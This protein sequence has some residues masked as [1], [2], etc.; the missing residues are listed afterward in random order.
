MS[1][2]WQDNIK[3]KLEDVSKKEPKVS[4]ATIDAKGRFW[5]WFQNK[6]EIKTS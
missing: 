2:C 6:V 3:A 5:F 4:K 1:E